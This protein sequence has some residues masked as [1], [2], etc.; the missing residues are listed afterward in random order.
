MFQVFGA[1]EKTRSADHAE[2]LGWAGSLAVEL[3]KDGT[4]LALDLRPAVWLLES[5]T[6][7]VLLEPARFCIGRV[8]DAS[9]GGMCPRCF[10][11]EVGRARAL[12][13]P[14][15]LVASVARKRADVLVVVAGTREDSGHAGAGAYAVLW[16]GR[17]VTLGG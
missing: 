4:G 13:R 9:R 6:T 16:R 3:S 5:G 8:F 7:G 11:S 10:I 12:L 14:V 1:L 2:K 15:K 17:E